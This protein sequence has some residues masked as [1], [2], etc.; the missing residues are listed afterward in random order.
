MKLNRRQFGTVV[1]SIIVAPMPIIEPP[2]TLE[3]ARKVVAITEFYGG[4]IEE[5]RRK[6]ALMT[7]D[8]CSAY[9][10]S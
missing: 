10:K 2:Y 8:I 1:G 7:Y 6:D 3:D 4:R 9:P 5:Y